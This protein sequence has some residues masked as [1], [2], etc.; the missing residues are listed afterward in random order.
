MT[1]FEFFSLSV[2]SIFLILTLFSG[3]LR[4]KIFLRRKT[5]WFVDLTGL[6]FHFFLLS[7]IQV[8]LVWKLYD[9]IIPSLKK[10]ISLSVFGSFLLYLVL[11]YCWYWNHRFLH[12]IKMLWSLH[13]IHHSPQSLDVL[14][15]SKNSI[16][17]YFFMIYF[18]YIGLAVYLLKDSFY[19]L[20]FESFGMTIN[21][22]GHTYFHLRRGSLLQKIVNLFFITP[23]EHFWHHSQDRYDCNFGT[24][25]NF[26]DKIHGTY[27]SPDHSP[28]FLGENLSWST[29]KQ[30]VIPFSKN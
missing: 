13:R 10:S 12:K 23:H 17:S 30:L 4:E 22:W 5:D 25:F 11:D 2:F 24:V 18:W 28:K 1:N 14:V 8:V 27:Y 20:L 21:Y 3:A 16:W 7:L 26:W 6:F 19:F 15:T 29:F 9:F